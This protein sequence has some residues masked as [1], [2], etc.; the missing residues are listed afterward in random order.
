MNDI[1][2]EELKKYMEDIDAKFKKGNLSQEKFDLI[3]LL[4]SQIEET[5]KLEKEF[6]KTMKKAKDLGVETPF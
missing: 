6:D 1:T 3:K 2:P 4:G 5:Y